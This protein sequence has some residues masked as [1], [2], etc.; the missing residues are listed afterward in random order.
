MHITVI[1]GSFRDNFSI[2]YVFNGEQAEHNS[3]AYPVAEYV[4]EGKDLLQ[5]AVNRVHLDLETGF[6]VLPD[7]VHEYDQIQ[8]AAVNY[9]C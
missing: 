9:D 5:A 4:E 3:K 1:I 2:N 7:K 8:P 6:A